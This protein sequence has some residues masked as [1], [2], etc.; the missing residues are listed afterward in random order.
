LTYP[1]SVCIDLVR[2][3]LR[4]ALPGL[5]A[6]LLMCPRPR[7]PGLDLPAQYRDGGVLLFL[8]PR[9]GALHLV[10][11]RRCDH[12]AVHAG[13]ISLPGGLR[14]P[15]DRSLAETALREA[16][17][18]LALDPAELELL[19]PLTPL[20]IPVSGYRIHP[21]VACSPLAPSFQPD[22]DE[23]AELLEVPLDGLLD[24]GM[25]GVETRTIRGR[26]VEVPFYRVGEHQVW[27]ATAMVLSELLELLRAA[28]R[29][30]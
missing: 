9:R 6:Q 25:A 29:P 22:P 30:L 4:L 23:V 19:G 14:E 1:E 27:G 3:A 16:R 20:E 13:Q 28:Q 15:R 21:W 5:S 10:L 2:R 8:Y 26:E 12:L 7:T 24:P 17:E 18:E 11:T